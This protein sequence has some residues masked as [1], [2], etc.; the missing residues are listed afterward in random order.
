[1]NLIDLREGTAEDHN[2]IYSSWL[3]SHREAEANRHL[4]N[5]VYY[6]N[7]KKVVQRILPASKIIVAC[8]AASPEHIFGYAVYDIV[9][10]VVILHYI[11]VKSPYRMMGIANKMMK[12]LKTDAVEDAPV[13]ATHVTRMFD[14]L[15]PKW[16]LVH[17][18]YVTEKIAG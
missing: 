9:G 14:I 8:D 18:P 7:H 15:K 13:I 5:E 6:G 12:E 4:P 1:M 17:N 2:F 16:K 10:G 3:K 11:Y